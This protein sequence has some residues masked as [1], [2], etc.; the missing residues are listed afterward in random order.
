MTA[1]GQRVTFENRNYLVDIYKDQ[2]PSIVYIKPSQMGISERLLSESVWICDQLGANVL[3]TFPAASQLVDF[4]QARLDPV[5]AYSDYLM[6]RSRDAEKYVQKIGLKRIGKGYLYLR[7][8]QNEKQITSI[9]ADAIFLDERDRFIEENVPYIDK[10]MQASSLRWR[11]SA[12]TPTYPSVEGRSNNIHAEFLESDQRIWVVKCDHCNE[13]QELDFFNNLYN[14]ELYDKT[15][16]V[17]AIYCAKCFKKIDPYKEGQW[18]P[19]KPSSNIH[20]YKIP[21]LC[22]PVR[23]P[24]DFILTF[25]KAQT[26]GFS[27]L[28]Q[29]Y[30]QVLGIPYEAQGQRLKVSDLD[31]CRRSYV[32]PGVASGCFAGAD[33]GNKIHVVISDK[34]EGRLRYLWIGT[35]DNFIGPINSLE[36]LINRYNVRFMVVD[37]RPDTRKVRE[38]INKFP[39]RVFAAFYPTS[40]FTVQDYYRFDDDKGEVNVDRTISLDYLVS[41]VQNQLIEIPASIDMI[42]DFYK[43]MV[44]S[45]RII[46]SNEKTGTTVAR[47]IESGADHYFHAANYNRIASIKDTV[48][49]V[50]LDYFR[51]PEAV[52]SDSLI[53]LA[54]RRGVRL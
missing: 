17:R 34:R 42:P 21:G 12:S 49:T 14:K 31:A 52:T 19:Q 23:T 11:R 30:N 4:V 36:S 28:Q 46:E 41:D 35:V 33:V 5:F 3:Y 15:T 51:T 53:R 47:W 9:D 6:G 54:L 43:Q 27:A 25:N 45:V 44:T 24:A 22:N 26:E 38:L 40:K 18:V 20:G 13:Y 50:L 8:S 39:G 7:G 10:R 32:F 16:G 29:F 37:A 1:R 2:Y 48:S